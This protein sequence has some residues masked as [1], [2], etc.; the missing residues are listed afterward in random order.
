MDGRQEQEQNFELSKENGYIPVD[1]A[2][3]RKKR[4]LLSC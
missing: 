2:L 4:V 3:K 1:G